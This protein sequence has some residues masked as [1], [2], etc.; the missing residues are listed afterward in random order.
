MTIKRAR[1][2]DGVVEI[3]LATFSS[4]D[5]VNRVRRVTKIPYGQRALSVRGPEI[6]MLFVPWLDIALSAKPRWDGRGHG[7]WV[8]SIGSHLRPVSAVAWPKQSLNLNAEQRTVDLRKSSQ[9]H[10]GRGRG[11]DGS[12]S[13]QVPPGKPLTVYALVRTLGK[14]SSDAQPGQCVGCTSRRPSRMGGRPCVL[15]VAWLLAH[16]RTA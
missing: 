4:H 11:H 13:L 2:L 12:T 14:E 9:L 8:V 6:D 3:D 1:R 15:L 10:K 7:P 16:P 5:G